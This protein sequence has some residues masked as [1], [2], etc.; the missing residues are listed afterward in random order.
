M[1][2]DM[3]RSHGG[4]CYQDQFTILG[5]GSV[6]SDGFNTHFCGLAKGYSSKINLNVHLTQN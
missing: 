3:A 5:G 4:F 1:A 6:E 2:A